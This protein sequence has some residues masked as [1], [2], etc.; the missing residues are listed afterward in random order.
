MNLCKWTWQAH[1]SRCF[2]CFVESWAE[3]ANLFEWQILQF[4]RVLGKTTRPGIWSQCG[5][6]DYSAIANNMSISL[7]I[8]RSWLLLAVLVMYTASFHAVNNGH[9]ARAG[10][11]FQPCFCFF[12]G[13]FTQFRRKL[14]EKIESTIFIRSNRTPKQS[15][16]PIQSNPA[17][18]SPAV[19]IIYIISL[20]K[21]HEIWRL[22]RTRWWWP[23]WYLLPQ[24][25]S[26]LNLQT[27][28][29]LK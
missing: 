12:R 8:P 27:S 23:C 9:A 5:R 26:R 3:K 20:Y 4:L 29:K 13:R 2:H 6:G 21:H 18:R 1:V 22:H 25:R 16:D 10:L 17:Y 7:R 19:D 15:L 28:S 14:T 11:L 24:S